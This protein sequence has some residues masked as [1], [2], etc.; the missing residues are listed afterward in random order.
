MRAIFGI[1]SLVIVLAIIGSIA[2][3]QLQA[4]NGGV[5][6]RYSQA[7]SQAAAV[8]ADPGTRDGATFMVPGGMPGGVAADPNGM[9][10]PQQARSMQEQAR[11]NTIRAL[12]EG[13][14]RNQRAEP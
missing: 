5:A 12:E 4:V 8:S 6:T 2:K 7:A 1:L 14:K 3:K 10:V 13:A 9:T 11:T